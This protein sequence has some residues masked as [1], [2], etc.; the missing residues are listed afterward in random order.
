[1]EL[2]CGNSRSKI[3]KFGID[4]AKNIAELANSNGIAT[5]ADFFTQEVAENVL[6]SWRT[7]DIAIARNVI[8]HVKEIHSVISGIKL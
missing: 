2:F 3:L 4:P 5:Q 1:M 7:A 6:K 8:P